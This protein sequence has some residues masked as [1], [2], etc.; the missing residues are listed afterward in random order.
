M[1]DF[2]AYSRDSGQQDS[3]TAAVPTGVTDG[4][5]LVAAICS[6]STADPTSAPSGWTL[7]GTADYK[8]YVKWHLYTKIASSESGSYTWSWSATTK[9]AV[10][11][12]AYRGDFDTADPIDVISNTEYQTNNTTLRAASI[13]LSQNNET[14]IFLGSQFIL[15]NNTCSAPTNPDTFTEDVDTG[16]STSDIYHHYYHLSGVSAGATGNIEGTLASSNY[17]KHAFAI[18]LNPMSNLGLFFGKGLS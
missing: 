9:R 3:L 4:D 16:D 8:T 12:A 6:Y 17:A 13:T 15:T 5:L 14:I 11:V 10:V 18:A 1:T 2:V 7:R